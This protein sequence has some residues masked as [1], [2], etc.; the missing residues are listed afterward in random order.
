MSWLGSM[1]PPELAARKLVLFLRPPGWP[2]LAPQLRS[3]VRY[4]ACLALAAQV[5]L[6]VAWV[7]AGALQPGYAPADQT[8]SELAARNAEHPWIVRT[9][10][11]IWG[12]GFVA[13][14]AAVTHTLRGAPWSRVA[15]ALF[16]A[17][18]VAIIAVGLLPLDCAATVDR[19]C[20]AR[21][22]AGALSWR[23]YGHHWAGLAFQLALLMT[24][25][26]LA[27]SEWPSRLGRLTLACGIVGVGIGVASFLSYTV[28]GAPHGVY[29]RLGLGIV[30]LWV[31]GVAGGLLIEASSRWPSRSVDEGP[32]ASLLGRWRRPG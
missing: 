10:H 25:F 14:G 7:V 23:H 28:E 26:A 3:R 27:R 32:F 30:H 15:P 24:P 4:L 2:L 13:L 6:T 9:A 21:E 17:C 29:Q 20:E 1:R 31:L 22:K 12:A 8:V 19:L 18:G 11:L 16:I 5:L